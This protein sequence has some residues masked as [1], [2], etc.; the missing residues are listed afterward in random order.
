MSVEIS[1]NRPPRHAYPIGMQKLL[2]DSPELAPNLRGNAV[3]NNETLL[4]NFYDAIE[5]DSAVVAYDTFIREPLNIVV[6]SGN[7]YYVED[8]IPLAR[9]V[10]RSSL[11][12]AERGSE[13]HRD[14]T[15]RLNSLN[16]FSPEARKQ[17]DPKR[18]T[19]TRIQELT[20]KR[21][22]A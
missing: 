14:L 8:T 7:R 17:R 10:L 1:T 4:I 11:T 20:T 12:N 18:K 13:E 16:R 2:Y 15:V 6:G 3:V 9:A 5:H 19:T 22:A 21:R